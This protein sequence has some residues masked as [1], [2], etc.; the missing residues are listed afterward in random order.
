[1]PLLQ[2]KIEVDSTV[3]RYYSPLGNFDSRLF[4]NVTILD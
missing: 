1:M 2:S 3:C 4:T